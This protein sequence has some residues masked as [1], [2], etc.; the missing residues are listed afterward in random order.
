VDLD[1]VDPDLE[2][3]TSSVAVFAGEYEVVVRAAAD[4][5]SLPAPPIIVS[6]PVAGRW[7]VSKHRPPPGIFDASIRRCREAVGSPAVAASP[8]STVTVREGPAT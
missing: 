8:W 1:L 6:L 5:R 7:I 4:Q 3:L 2:S